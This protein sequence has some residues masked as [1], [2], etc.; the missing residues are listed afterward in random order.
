MLRTFG[1][2]L[3]AVTLTAV[4]GVAAAGAADTPAGPTPVPLWTQSPSSSPTTNPTG[5]PTP[6][7][8]PTVACPPAL[9]IT[10][11]VTGTTATTVTISYSLMFSGPPCGYDLPMTVLL[12]TSRDDAAKWQNPAVKAVTGLERNGQVTVDGL[13]PDTEYWFRFSDARDRRDPY[14][15]GGPVRTQP[16]SPCAAT[17]TIDARWGSG[18]VATVTVRNTGSES[19]DG[20]L[21]RWR[22]SGDER[23]QS[24]WGGVPDSAGADVTVGNAPYNGTVGPGGTTTFGLL[25]SASTVPQA[26][27]LTCGR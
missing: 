19:L 25:A 1:V 2:V 4:A 12:F 22:W 23:L 8:T 13:F 27:T 3:T 9:P 5:G 18:F 16:L 10:G 17:A 11:M 20:W 26:I 15:I 14:V 24:V 7:P 6:T 21:V